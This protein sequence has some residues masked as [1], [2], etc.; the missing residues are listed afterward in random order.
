MIFLRRNKVGLVQDLRPEIPILAGVSLVKGGRAQQ[1]HGTPARRLGHAIDDAKSH[2]MGFARLGKQHQLLGLLYHQ[3]G[4]ELDAPLHGISRCR[5][6]RS[7][8]AADFAFGYS[9]RDGGGGRA[10]DIVL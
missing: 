9:K 5:R 4:P 10:I 3:G 1:E 8:M 7:M 6:R 2:G